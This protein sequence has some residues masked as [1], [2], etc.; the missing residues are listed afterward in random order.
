MVALTNWSD[1]MLPAHNH[2]YHLHDEF[3]V[4]I[5]GMEVMLRMGAFLNVR[6][7]YN[8]LQKNV[9]ETREY[10]DLPVMQY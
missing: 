7:I 3:I 2:D 10:L 6:A 9:H 4:R 1:P 8:N 5:R